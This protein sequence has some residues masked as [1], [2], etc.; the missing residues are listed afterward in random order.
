MKEKGK[1]QG[2][3]GQGNQSFF[4]GFDNYDNGGNYN[5]YIYIQYH[6]NI[7]KKSH[8]YSQIITKMLW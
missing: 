5:I 2:S 1:G 6:R 8:K 7:H 3:P 4:F